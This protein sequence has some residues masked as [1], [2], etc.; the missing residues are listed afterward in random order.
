MQVSGN[1]WAVVGA[2]CSGRHT[3]FEAL[4]RHLAHDSDFVFLKD[5]G[6]DQ[7]SQLLGSLN[8]I[9][10]NKLHE[11]APKATQLGI[12][13]ARLSYVI[14]TEVSPLLHQ[15]KTVIMLGFGGTVLTHALCG[16]TCETERR[17]LIALHKAFIR[18]C[19]IGLRVPPPHYL[20]LQVSAEIA[21]R[22][23]QN[24]PSKVNDDLKGHVEAMNR[25]YNFYGSLPGQT[26][27]PLNGD[28]APEEVL[29]DALRVLETPQAVVA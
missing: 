17:N 2:T 20:W 25:L 23:A 26:V 21:H 10:K 27:T 18:S 6:S 1:F 7:A 11:A 3:L 16:V 5:S 28:H 14:Q 29:E 24:K 22:R 8:H 4:Q 19:V 13:W 9:A 15:G 12:F